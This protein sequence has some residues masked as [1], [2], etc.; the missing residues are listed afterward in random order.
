MEGLLLQSVGLESW[1]AVSSGL[2]HA[3]LGL[4]SHTATTVDM[5]VHTIYNILRMLLVVRTVVTCM[6]IRRRTFPISP[7]TEYGLPLY[8]A[9]A[10]QHV[11]MEYNMLDACPPTSSPA[12]TASQLRLGVSGNVHD[13]EAVQ[14]TVPLLRTSAIINSAGIEQQILEREMDWNAFHLP[15][16]PS[17]SA[18]TTLIIELGVISSNFIHPTNS[19]CNPKHQRCRR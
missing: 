4:A 3:A 13:A 11:Y 7:C 10:C 19:H 16:D 14:S 8:R 1:D 9:G 2:R 15:K 17:L 12:I 18:P 5:L 6:Y